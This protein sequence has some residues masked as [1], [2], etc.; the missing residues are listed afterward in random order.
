M[1]GDGKSKSDLAVECFK[2]GFNC[3]QSVFTAFSGDMGMDSC[4]A[5]KVATAFGGGIAS[6]GNVCGAVSGG[7]MAIGLRH[8]RCTIDDL[9]AKEKTYE[10]SR[11]FMDEFK[12][13]HGSVVCKEVLGCDLNT[14]EGKAEFASRN[15][16]NVKC[17]AC[18]RDAVQILENIL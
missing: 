15:L 12:A 14:P 9:K 7:L 17:T 5:L 1:S 4:T 10:I 13:R 6:T 2:S 8:G 16:I 18:V 3:S 11:R